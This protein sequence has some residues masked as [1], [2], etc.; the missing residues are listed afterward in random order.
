MELGHRIKARRK[1]LGMTQAALADAAGV[2][3]ISVCLIENGRRR[4]RAETVAKFAAA[5]QCSPDDLA[6]RHATSQPAA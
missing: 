5:L 1:A 2:H 6:E 4:P 3:E